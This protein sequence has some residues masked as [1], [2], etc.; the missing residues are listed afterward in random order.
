MR[1]LDSGLDIRGDLP[2]LSMDPY[3]QLYVRA[4]ILRICCQLSLF[5]S[6]VPIGCDRK[7]L[8]RDAP[9]RVS[10]SRFDSHS[11]LKRCF[12][13]PLCSLECFEVAFSTMTSPACNVWPRQEARKTTTRARIAIFNTTRQRYELIKIYLILLTRT[14][15]A[16]PQPCGD[17]AEESFELYSPVTRGNCR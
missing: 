1:S 16:S 14:I 15:F 8:E 11:D 7:I 17:S 12:T 2:S 9:C 4:L 3:R 6:A 13:A 5:G 10:G